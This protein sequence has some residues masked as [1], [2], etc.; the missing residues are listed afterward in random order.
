MDDKIKQLKNKINY[1][2]DNANDSFKMYGWNNSHELRLARI[3]GCLD[4]L[5][6]LTSKEYYYDEN[7]LHER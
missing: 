6:I 2:I 7:G 1:L 5:S 4:A 3:D